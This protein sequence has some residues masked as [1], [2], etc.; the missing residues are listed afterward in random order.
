VIAAIPAEST[1]SGRPL[2]LIEKVEGI[3]I[4]QAAEITPHR[5]LA[6]ATLATLRELWRLPPE[7]SGLG[8][9]EPVP[10]LAEIDRWERL[11]ERPPGFGPGSP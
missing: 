8:G 11:A 3:G 6:A 5:E 7:E 10:A 2:L 4:G 9:E 1:S